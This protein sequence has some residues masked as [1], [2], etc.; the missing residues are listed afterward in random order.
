MRTILI[1]SVFFGAIGAFADDQWTLNSDTPTSWFE[2]TAWSNGTYPQSGEAVT[3][4]ASSDNAKASVSLQSGD[5]VSGITDLTFGK[6]TGAQTYL[7]IPSGASLTCTG[8][9]KLMGQAVQKATGLVEIAGGTLKGKALNWGGHTSSKGTIRIT[10]NG[11]AEFTSS[12]CGWLGPSDFEIDTGSLYVGPGNFLFGNSATAYARLFGRN[13]A[14]ETTGVSIGANASG[15]LGAWFLED[16]AVNI[17]GSVGIVLGRASQSCLRITNT[18]VRFTHATAPFTLGQ[19][20]NNTVTAGVWSDFE[21]VGENAMVSNSYRV[22]LFNNARYVQRGG[23]TV[24]QANNTGI[25]MDMNGRPGTEQRVEVHGGTFSLTNANTGGDARIILGG[26]GKATFR[27]T[28]G[29]VAAAGILFRVWGEDDARYEMTGGTLNLDDSEA[30][31]G[32]I[33][34]L[35]YYSNTK[36]YSTHAGTFSILGGAPD[37]WMTR[38]GTYNST[39]WQPMIEY[40]ICTNFVAPI[41]FSR[42][43]QT[44]YAWVSGIYTIVPQGGMQLIHTNTVML[45]DGRDGEHSISLQNPGSGT[46]LPNAALWE[47]GTTDLYGGSTTYRLGSRLRASAAFEPGVAPDTPVSCGYVR[48]PKTSQ[49]GYKV[50]LNLLPQNDVTLGELIA[51]LIAAG[52]P[53]Q[54]DSS[55]EGY[56]VCAT[57]PENLVAHGSE[58]E[59]LVFDFARHVTPE[60]V[61]NGTPTVR[62]LVGRVLAEK[63]TTGIVVLLH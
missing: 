20:T 24:I 61:R 54:A 18:V 6:N 29:T 45:L 60:D 38:I 40:V 37:I 58:D 8:T 14:I 33:R 62:A 32:G 51:D 53:A 35:E 15:A 56:N 26:S 17:T 9:I 39:N 50:W 55:R 27:Q 30:G 34:S 25:Q 11:R 36:I 1:V 44:Y 46:I 43:S 21:M 48:L 63:A 16:S 2:P 4:G 7:T 31:E 22:S 41:H 42:P 52:Y 12:T 13:A 59:Y 3:I 10:D 57:V 28:G 19:G 5:A 23:R 49:K 47:S